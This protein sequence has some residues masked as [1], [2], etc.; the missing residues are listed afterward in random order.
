MTCESLSGSR[1]MRH[2]YLNRRSCSLCRG[3][4]S[5]GAVAARHAD[6]ARRA[7]AHQSAQWRRCPPCG[8][9]QPAG[10]GSQGCAC[11]GANV[12][13][14]SPAFGSSAEVDGAAARLGKDLKD[15]EYRDN[16][17]GGAYTHAPIVMSQ[18]AGWASVQ[19]VC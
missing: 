14:S 1:S 6:A 15:K 2:Y 3:R 19:W 7:A 5:S 16:V 18:V 11:A 9:G 10:V 12:L 17:Y 13:D 4:V 8:A